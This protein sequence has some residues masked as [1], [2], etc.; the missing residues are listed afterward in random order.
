MRTLPDFLEPS[1]KFGPSVRPKNACIIYV[2]GQEDGK[3][4]KIGKTRNP[5]EI[6]LAQHEQ[7][8]PEEKP[9]RP[10][11]LVWGQDADEKALK[12]HW[13]KYAVNGGNEWLRP[14]EPLR[15]WIR[16]L[17]QQSYIATEVGDELDHKPFVDPRHWLPESKHAFAAKQQSLPFKDDPWSDLDFEELPGDG[18]FY[19]NPIIIDAARQAMGGVDLDPA[20]CR[21]ANRI[22]RATRFFNA[23]IDGLVH[24]WDAEKIWLN[25]PFNQWDQW[26]PKIREELARGIIEQLCV[27]IPTRSLTVKSLH[28]LLCRATAMVI[29]NGRIPFHGPKAGAPDD[30]HAVFYFGR[31]LA[32]FHLAFQPLGFTAEIKAKHG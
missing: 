3:Y 19:T 30:G 31:N 10:L 24:K 8:G 5:I 18:D 20:S 9:M 17:R 2:L 21:E 1:P 13:K 23:S 28:S 4:V 7:R 26:A 32:H 12:R 16:F 11:A 25:P 14:E 15:E 6:R 29:F 22:V 27:L